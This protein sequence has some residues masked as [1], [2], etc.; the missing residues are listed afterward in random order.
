MGVKKGRA[1]DGEKRKG[2]GRN[3]CGGLWLGKVGWLRVS[4][5]R[6]DYGGEMG[7]GLRVGKRG[8]DMGG[9]KGEGLW[10]G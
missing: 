1:R 7:E 2:Y 4:K 5:R 10:V 3:N 9:K 6:K 8:R